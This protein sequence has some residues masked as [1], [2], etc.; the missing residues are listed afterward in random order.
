MKDLIDLSDCTVFEQVQA[1][2]DDY[3]DYYNHDKY[4]WGLCKLSP[5]E[6]YSFVTTGEYP[7]KG[8][9]APAVPTDFKD[10]SMIGSEDK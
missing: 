5:N 8:I 2:V 4:Q 3:I 1:K 10:P 6:Y 9:P 7:I